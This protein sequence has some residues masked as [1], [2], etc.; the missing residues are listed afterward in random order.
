M[1]VPVLPTSSNVRSTDINPETDNMD[2]VEFDVIAKV[3]GLIG[4]NSSTKASIIGTYKL[5]RAGLRPQ[6]YDINLSKIFINS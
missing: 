3:G 5:V 2:V 6:T 1:F 4:D